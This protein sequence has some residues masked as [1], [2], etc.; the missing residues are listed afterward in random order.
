MSEGGQSDYG[1]GDSGYS[2]APRAAARSGGGAAWSGGNFDK[3]LDDEE[4]LSKP[5]VTS[6]TATRFPVYP[7]TCPGARSGTFFVGA[8]PSGHD[9]ATSPVMAKPCSVWTG[10]VRFAPPLAR[11]PPLPWGEVGWMRV[12]QQ[13]GEGLESLR[14]GA[15]LAADHPL[16]RSRCSR[17]LPLGEVVKPR[18]P[19][20]RGEGYALIRWVPGLVPAS[21]GALPIW[22][23]SL[24]GDDSG[25]RPSRFNR[26]RSGPTCIRGLP[27]TMTSRRS[28]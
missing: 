8:E 12:A 9:H 13:P 27:R 7:S 23:R 26:T 2:D 16:T 22:T 19:V 25:E 24:A 18:G 21:W 1:G 15:R 4:F 20:T 3:Q 6:F 28:E 10:E 17:P 5:R 14:P 11:W